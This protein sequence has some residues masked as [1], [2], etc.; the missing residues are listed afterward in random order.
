VLLSVV[1]PSY[2]Y[3]RYLREC[4][5][6]V[7]EQS[8]SDWELL[9]VDDGSIDNSLAIASSFVGLDRRVKL[10]HQENKGYP[11]A[12]NVG[13][14]AAT[15]EYVL[16]LD[17]DDALSNR[18]SLGNLVC[19]INTRG[20]PVAAWGNGTVFC[21]G[22]RLRGYRKP[23]EPGSTSGVNV[24]RELLQ[25]DFIPLG[26]LVVRADVARH[27]GFDERVPWLQDWP[28]KLRTALRGTCVYVAADVLA[29]RSHADS[30]SQD[31]LRC[32]TDS[33]AALTL[34]EDE[35]TSAG[36]RRDYL[37]SR[38]RYLYSW[39]R[40]EQRQRRWTRSMS[41][42]SQALKTPSLVVVAKSAVRLIHSLGMALM[43]RLRGLESS[44]S[45]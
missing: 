32:A 43:S 28:Y 13:L 38:S 25:G 31:R 33:V 14:T 15:G 40:E 36:L 35:L 9:I 26:C 4:I 5:C 7:R 11:S 30:V 37:T 27:V 42:F 6:S 19:A 29:V 17:A 20:A 22:Q 3:G 8:F 34:L 12:H 41:S 44:S 39:G 21:D 10:L 18:D 2:N 45:R 24:A 16:V 1:V 23:F